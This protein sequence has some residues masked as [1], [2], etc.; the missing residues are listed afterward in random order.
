MKTERRTPNTP[1]LTTNSP[2]S[3]RPRTSDLVDH[4]I[5]TKFNT[6]I[7]WDPKLYLRNRRNERMN[8]K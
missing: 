5:K 6:F 2:A 1:D 4:Q 7:N 3:S 8:K